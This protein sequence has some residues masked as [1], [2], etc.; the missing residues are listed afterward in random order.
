MANPKYSLG[1]E[2]QPPKINDLR[3]WRL[4]ILATKPM[5]HQRFYSQYCELMKEGLVGWALG[6]AYLKPAG[7]MWLINN[8][9]MRKK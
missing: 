6:T 5:W 7:M 8:S 2:Y 1:V 9:D 4:L 3:K